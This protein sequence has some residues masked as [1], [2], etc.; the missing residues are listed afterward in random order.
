MKLKWN[1]R[2]AISHQLKAPY[3]FFGY[4]FL[5]FLVNMRFRL[6]SWYPLSVYLG[7][8]YGVLLVRADA[9]FSDPLV[10]Y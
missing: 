8:L 1:P 9:A 6:V 3:M 2:Q 10:E 7:L 4:G 5:V